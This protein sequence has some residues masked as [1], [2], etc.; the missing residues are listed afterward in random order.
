MLRKLFSNDEKCY[1]NI[2]KKNEEN[3]YIIKQNDSDDKLERKLKR[4]SGSN[5]SNNSSNRKSNRDRL[6]EIVD[7]DVNNKNI[8][9]EELNIHD[10]LLI[11]KKYCH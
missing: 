8:K 9:K 2:L 10:Y 1:N 4:K 6:S 3:Q 7:D 11:R 5:S